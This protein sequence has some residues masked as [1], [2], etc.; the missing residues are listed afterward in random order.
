MEGALKPV[1]ASNVW[2]LPLHGPTFSN[3]VTSPAGIMSSQI[4]GEKKG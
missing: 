1:K 4:P 3:A 2:L